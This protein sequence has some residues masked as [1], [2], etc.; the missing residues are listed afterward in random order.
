MALRE[1]ALTT[2][3]DLRNHIG[4]QSLTVA[5]A[6]RAI[7]AMSRTIRNYCGRQFVPREGDQTALAKKFRYDGSGMLVL[8]ASPSYATELRQ[9]TS[10]VL[11]SD[12][13]SA[14][15]VTLSAGT[16]NVTEADYRLEPRQGTREGTYL[17]LT[18]PSIPPSLIP[19]GPSPGGY[20]LEADTKRIEVTITG[21]WGA[22]D[23]PEDVE[24]ACLIAA[25]NYLRNPEAFQSRSLGDF[26]FTESV[27]T[28]ID[29]GQSLPRDARALL[30]DYRRD[31][32]LN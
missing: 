5:R 6:E 17:W 1:D 23:V 8:G 2:V 18:L 12:L 20:T 3:A 30:Y 7:N 19:D 31:T 26:S 24:A 13:P 29:T 27:P 16:A 25:T 22:G 10:I 4:E 14:N 15:Q 11:F 9:V 28:A 32:Y 21:K